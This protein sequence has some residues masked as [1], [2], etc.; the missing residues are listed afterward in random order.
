DL[1]HREELRQLLTDRRVGA[2]AE[3]LREFH[4][5]I[6]RGDASAARAA[7]SHLADVV[8]RPIFQLVRNRTRERV[9]R[10]TGTTG[11]ET[12]APR[13]PP[14]VEPADDRVVAYAR[15][16]DE[17][18]IEQRAASHLTQRPDLDAGL[19]HVE[20]EVR[21]PLVLRQLRR[22]AREQHALVGELRGRRPHLL[23]G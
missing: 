4:E 16:V 11:A 14:M 7:R 3:L 22:G 20:L 12:R 17:D 6:R 18:F 2:L 9:A 1:L 23:A 5:P 15:A 19:L 8:A 13:R 21:D 10:R